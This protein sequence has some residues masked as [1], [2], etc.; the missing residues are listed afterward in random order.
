M[1]VKATQEDIPFLLEVA[2]RVYKD[3]AFDVDASRAWLEAMVD[4]PWALVMRGRYGG[5]VTTITTPFYSCE[6]SGYLAFICT[7]PNRENEGQRM[8]RLAA[9]WCKRDKAK[10]YFGQKTGRNFKALAARLGAKECPPT[11][12]LEA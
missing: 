5:C 11:F 1:I 4:Q 8:I 9:D 2:K 10:L 6:K 12:V 3:H 7:L